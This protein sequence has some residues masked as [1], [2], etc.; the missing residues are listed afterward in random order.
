MKRAIVTGATGFIGKHL[1]KKLLDN[2][3]EVYGIGRN[4][5]AFKELN[6]YERFHT[7]CLDFQE[8]SRIEQLI[9]DKGFDFFFHLAHFGVNGIDKSNY[10]I[11]LENTRVACD[12]VVLAKKL[13][14]K[15]FLYAGSVDEFEAYFK[16][17]QKFTLPSHTRIYGLAKFTAENMGKAIAFDLGIDYVSVLLSLTYGEGNKTNILPNV[18][19]RNSINGTPTRLISGDNYF[20]M[21]YI[22]E[23]VGG[24]LAVA[25][26]G[27]NLESYFIGHEKLT[28]FKEYVELIREILGSD[29]EMLYG[30][31]DDPDYIMDY[32]MIDRKKLLMDTGYECNGNIV[33]SI[34][35]TRDWLIKQ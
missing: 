4:K 9:T 6:T 21:I 20:D 24:I 28:T 31:Y 12:L 3:V 5:E 16:P 32:T 30:E 22:D 14:C 29:G 17:D 7:I 1:C 34:L 11:Q 27:I 8:Y 26:R 25:E 18:I 15:R 33:E 2:G 23:A 35:K 19:I 10:R 13:G